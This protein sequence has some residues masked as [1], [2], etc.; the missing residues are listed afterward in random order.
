MLHVVAPRAG[1]GNVYNMLETLTGFALKGFRCSSTA[2]SG[3]QLLG[4]PLILKGVKKKIKTKPKKSTKPKPTLP[5]KTQRV[6]KSKTTSQL[7]SHIPSP[8]F[9]NHRHGFFHH[10]ATAVTRQP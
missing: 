1:L 8:L 5:K 9:L 10:I 3:E 6:L 2:P 7:L 4:F